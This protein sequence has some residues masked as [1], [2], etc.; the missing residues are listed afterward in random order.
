MGILSGEP[1]DRPPGTTMNMLWTQQSDLHFPANPAVS[2]HSIRDHFSTLSEYKFIKLSQFHGQPQEPITLGTGLTS[3]D[4]PVDNGPN[5]VRRQILP[6]NIQLRD[7]FVF[8]YINFAKKGAAH[9]EDK[10]NC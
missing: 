3:D 2:Y 6:S 1:L 10:G 4:L 9:Y 5:S 8:L 7:F